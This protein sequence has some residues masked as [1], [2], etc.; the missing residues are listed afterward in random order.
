MILFAKIYS[1]SET[2][3]ALQMI[4]GLPE[5]VNCPNAVRRLEV[6][7]GD[8]HKKYCSLARERIQDP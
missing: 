1:L 4:E 8:R 2:W 7:C 5:A 6:G 3:R